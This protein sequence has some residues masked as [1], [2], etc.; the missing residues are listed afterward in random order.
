MDIV[1]L[2]HSSFRLKGRTASLVTDPFDPSYVG[3]KF[4]RVSADII[5]ISH[6]HIDHN[7]K[8]LVDEVKKVISG[9]GEYEIMEVSIIG[10]AT[11]HDAKKGVERGKNT[12]Y[13]VEID[14]IRIAHLGDLGHKLNEKT[15]EG[16]GEIDVLMIPVGGEYTVGPSEAVQI[17]QMIEP[18]ITIPMHYF[19]EGMNKEKFGKL[20]K[21]E[22]FLKETGVS[23]TREKKL[24]VKASDLSEEQ[25]I[26]V[27]DAK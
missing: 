10:I 17:M 1:Y 18:S 6:D 16:I 7:K 25:K 3:L 4:P 27:M 20:S 15:F 14:G 11:F 21:V 9:P 22:D 2:G 13:V 24:S 12:I 26:V 5:T 8:E 19:V 23:V